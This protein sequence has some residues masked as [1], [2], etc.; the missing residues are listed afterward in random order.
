[1]SFSNIYKISKKE[2]V[3]NI[4]NYWFLLSAFVLFLTNFFIVYFGDIISG[5]YSQ[6]DI[7]ALLLSIIHLQMYLIPL[8]AFTLSYDAILSEK[9]SGTFDLILSYRVSLLDILLGKLFGNSVIFALSFVVGFLPVSFYLYF[10]GLKFIIVIK[11]ILFSIWLSFIFNSFAIYISIYS[12]DRTIVILLSIFMWIFF[13]FLYDLIFTFFVTSFYGDISNS[14]LNL[15]LFF[16]PAE[17]FR[18][19][20]IFYFMPLDANDLFGINVGSLSLLTIIFVMLFWIVFVFL[21]F[22][23]IYFRKK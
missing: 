23:V 10:L 12:N 19:I 14:I 13:L 4:K 6:T 1:M 16:N 3:H 9:E 22:F 8:F 11:F 15:L 20:S 21:G 2:I 7:R 18:L 5:D 17:V